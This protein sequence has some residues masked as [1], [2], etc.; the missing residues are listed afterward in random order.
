M[1]KFDTLYEAA[2]DNYGLI[3]ASEARDMGVGDKDLAVYSKRGWLER[4]GHGVYRLT[5]YVPHR[6]DPYAEAVTL[7]GPESIVWGESVLAMGELASVNPGKITVASPKRVR[8]KLPA[9]IEVVRLPKGTRA[10]WFDGIPSQSVADA[11]RT[12]VD[13]VMGERLVQAVADAKG[14]GLIGVSE[15]DELER[16]L[17]L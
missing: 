11:I 16:E 5:R 9:W 4:R 10:G 2:M 3:T 6:L 8:R 7:V 1:T 17:G 14:A 13:T 12:C 15:A